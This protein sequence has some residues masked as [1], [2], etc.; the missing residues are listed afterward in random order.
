[1]TSKKSNILTETKP[2][3]ETPVLKDPIND[4]GLSKQSALYRTYTFKNPKDV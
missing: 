4:N 2:R 1:M 3:K